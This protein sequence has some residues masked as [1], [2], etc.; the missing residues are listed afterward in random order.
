M[1]V[2]CIQTVR[3][4]AQAKHGLCLR[5]SFAFVRDKRHQLQWCGHTNGQTN[6]Q[7]RLL[8]GICKAVLPANVTGIHFQLAICTFSVCLHLACARR[9]LSASV[10]LS[11]RSWCASKLI[12]GVAA[13]CREAMLLQPVIF[14]CARSSLANFP[15]HLRD[16]DW[17]FSSFGVFAKTSSMPSKWPIDYDFSQ[18]Q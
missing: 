12:G 8:N 7:R 15:R 14:V 4:Q 16:S 10:P 2:H 11:R 9:A 18:C 3:S 13:Q 17:R 1:G 6:A 5:R